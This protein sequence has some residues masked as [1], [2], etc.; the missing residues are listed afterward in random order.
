[1][2]LLKEAGIALPD[3]TSEETFATNLRAALVAL[4]AGREADKPDDLTEVPGGTF[5]STG[6]GGMSAARA[7]L[8]VDQ[9][10]KNLR[11]P[12]PPQ[13]PAAPA[14]PA[15][16]GEDPR[17]GASLTRSHGTCASPRS[18]PAAP[19]SSAWTREAEQPP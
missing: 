4:R 18:R 8:I 13:K 15:L 11:L 9:V 1:M 7:Q 10:A 6:T 2:K 12:P 3:N 17:P 16:S 5:M 19:A 14:S